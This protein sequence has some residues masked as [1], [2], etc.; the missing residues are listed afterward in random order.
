MDTLKRYLAENEVE[1]LEKVFATSESIGGL[2]PNPFVSVTSPYHS[3]CAFSSHTY[4]MLC[5]CKFVTNNAEQIAHL[6][7]VVCCFMT[8]F[9]CYSL[10][11]HLLSY[12]VVK[13]L[14]GARH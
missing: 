14:P 1:Y 5:V 13:F 7:L 12:F 8:L 11:E 4:N 3:L 10:Y 6:I 2:L 9:V